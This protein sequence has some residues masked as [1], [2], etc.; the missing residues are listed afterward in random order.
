VRPTNAAAAGAPRLQSESFSAAEL[1][2][3]LRPAVEQMRR[4]AAEAKQR[5]ESEAAAAAARESQPSAQTAAPPPSPSTAA[6]APP[7]TAPPAQA[8][9]AN[10]S[11][12]EIEA[13]LDGLSPILRAQSEGLAASRPEDPRAFLLRR[14]ASWL[15]LGGMP[16]EQNGRT[17]VVAPVAALEAIEAARAAANWPAALAASEELIWAAPFCV[18]AQ[19]LSYESLGE[20]G[21]A[22]GAARDTALGLLRY[23]AQRFA[24]AMS[25]AFSDGRPYADEATRALANAGQGGGEARDEMTAAIGV[26]RALMTAGKAAEAMEALSAPL[27]APASGRRRMVWQ[28]AQVRFCLQHGFIVATLPL[29][30]YLDQMVSARDL[31]VWEPELATSVAELRMLALT[32]ADSR[33]ALSDERRRNALDEARG[34]IARLDLA[35]AVRLLRA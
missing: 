21:T 29:I 16:A 31:E 15:R 28:L 32:H 5:A 18:D 10:A 14:M 23:F 12:P 11:L 30:E 25:L 34:R 6:N 13:A 27:R 2:R 24:A 1:T 26:A 19:R 33:L 35:A 3:L 7:L 4:L 22:F 9:G 8:P 17:P 20:M